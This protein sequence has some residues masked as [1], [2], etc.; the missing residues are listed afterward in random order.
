MGKLDVRPSKSSLTEEG[1]AYALAKRQLTLGNFALAID[2][3]RK[4]IRQN[5]QSADAHNGLAVAYDRIGRHDLSRESYEQAL[6]LSPNDSAILANLARSLAA[7]GKKVESVAVAAKPAASSPGARLE[8]ISSREVALVTSNSG[9]GW[10]AVGVE[11]TPRRV[12]PAAPVF[13]QSRRGVLE[14]ALEAPEAAPSANHNVPVVILNAVGRRGLA[15]RMSNFLEDKGWSKA[16][17]GDARLRPKE[18]LMFHAPKDRLAAVQLSRSLPFPSRLV[19][20]PRARQVILFV[21]R[22]AMAFDEQLRSART[23]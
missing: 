7:A 13:A 3:F 5:P 6:A 14:I 15:R 1:D 17:V 20:A 16:S 4:A 23:S 22:N 12:A 19:V 2:G 21:G 10:A 11:A 8:R 9:A 18:S